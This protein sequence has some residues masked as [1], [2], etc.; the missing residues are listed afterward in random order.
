MYQENIASQTASDAPA[1][2]APPADQTPA[3]DDCRLIIDSRFGTLAIAP[4]SAVKFPA[5]LLGFGEFHN[6]ALAELGDPRYPHLKVLQSLDDYNLSFLVLPLDPESG[7]IESDDISAACESLSIEV[8][9]VAFLLVVTVRKSPE[10]VVVSANLRAPLLIDT[11][12]RTGVQYVL[13]NDR[14]PVRYRL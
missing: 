6:Y 11:V 1:N 2:V 14:Y 7:I 9:N 12:S 13:P 10:G 3:P 8:A 4:Q 5:G